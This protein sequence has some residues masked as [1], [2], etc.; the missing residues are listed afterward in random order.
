MNYIWQCQMLL[1]NSE[2]KLRYF[3]NLPYYKLIKK[4]HSYGPI[5][6][7]LEANY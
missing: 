2:H 4:Y 6:G 1:G 3:L 5:K 7:T